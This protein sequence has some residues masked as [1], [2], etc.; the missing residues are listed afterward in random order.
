[1]HKF[2]LLALISKIRSQCIDT[3]N[4]TDKHNYN[5]NYYLTKGICRNNDLVGEH[6]AGA[7]YNFP[8]LN[9]CACGK[10]ST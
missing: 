9:C 7:L 6:Y 10:P 1:M 4:W 8:E 2:I 5:C 3:I